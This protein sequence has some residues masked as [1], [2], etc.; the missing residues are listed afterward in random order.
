MFIAAESYRYKVKVLDTSDLTCEWI[1]FKDAVG[2]IQR[3]YQIYGLTEQSAESCERVG[4]VLRLYRNGKYYDYDGTLLLESRERRSC[5]IIDFLALE[6]EFYNLE[7]FQWV[8]NIVRKHNVISY[9][10]LAKKTIPYSWMVTGDSVTGLDIKNIHTGEQRYGLTFFDCLA[11]YYL[12]REQI[13]DIQI[14]NRSMIWLWNNRKFTDLAVLYSFWSDVKS[15]QTGVNVS[16]LRFDED[17]QATWDSLDSLFNSTNLILA[18]GIPLC[19]L[20]NQIVSKINENSE[21]P[22]FLKYTEIVGTER[23]RLIFSSGETIGDPRKYKRISECV[24]YSSALRNEVKDV[25]DFWLTKMQVLD[26][27]FSYANSPSIYMK[28]VNIGLRKIDYTLKGEDTYSIRTDNGCMEIRYRSLPKGLWLARITNTGSFWVD[29]K[30]QVIV[31]G[32]MK[33]YPG[34]KPNDFKADYERARARG[35]T[36]VNDLI[37]PLYIS[38]LGYIQGNY[39][40]F[41][42]CIVSGNSSG[43]SDTGLFYIELPLYFCGGKLV[44]YRDFYEYE[45]MYST[46]KMDKSFVHSLLAHW[47]YAHYR[48]HY[49]FSPNKKYKFG[50][51]LLED[52]MF[53]VMRD[54]FGDVWEAQEE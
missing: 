23:N 39:H 49:L 13:K 32:T 40:V 41:V 10:Y 20:K 53:K 47:D 16:V 8:I 48:A 14:C 3:G 46:I 18:R 15:D 36:F 5:S 26:P 52:N 2:I 12:S 17:V 43:M 29:P 24:S 4:L 11:L 54:V 9:P 51:Q 6:S 7:V 19:N 28:Y 42:G 44:E 37:V 45:T 30:N 25:I 38:R 34:I 35:I 27:K 33:G 50:I 21:L 1:S 31:S 22:W